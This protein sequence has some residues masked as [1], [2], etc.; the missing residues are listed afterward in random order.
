[1]SRSIASCN[2]GL[3][4]GSLFLLDGW[5]AYIG[6]VFGGYVNFSKELFSYVRLLRQIAGAAIVVLSVMGE[7]Y[8]YGN[9]G[10]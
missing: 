1:M 9:V 6:W 10:K 8:G 5:F 3:F 2:F 7:I 4:W